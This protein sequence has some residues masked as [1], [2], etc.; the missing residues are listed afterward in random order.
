MALPPTCQRT[1]SFRYVEI[2]DE[3]VRMGSTALTR[4]LI[5]TVASCESCHPAH[6]WLGL[7]SPVERI[8]EFG[9]WQVHHIDG[10]V[11]EPEE[12]DGLA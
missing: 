4:K 11:A 7:H 2:A 10:K 1:F 6:D 12:I 9:L 8:R 3:K 5:A